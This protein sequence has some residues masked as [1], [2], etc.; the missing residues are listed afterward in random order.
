MAFAVAAGRG[1][2]KR[3]FRAQK[4]VLACATFD[5]DGN[6]MLTTDGMFPCHEITDKYNKRVH[7]IVE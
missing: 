4:V 6:V 5:P 1:A 7:Q 2:R 3:K